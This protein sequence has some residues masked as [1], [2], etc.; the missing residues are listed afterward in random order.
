MIPSM[1]PC[2]FLRWACNNC[3]PLEEVPVEDPRCSKVRACPQ[4]GL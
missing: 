3:P 4:S 1:A 2:A